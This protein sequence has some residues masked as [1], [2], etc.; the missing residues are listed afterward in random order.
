MLQEMHELKIQQTGS[1]NVEMDNA[2]SVDLTRVLEEFRE[3][4][5]T[6]VKK[7]KLELEKWFQSKVRGA[8]MCLKHTRW[9][10]MNIK[11]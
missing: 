6:V 7:N 3:K 11:R 8:E 4:Y 9:L 10:R 5:E 1:V 2:E